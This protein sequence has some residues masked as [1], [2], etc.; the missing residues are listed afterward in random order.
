MKS[1]LTLTNPKVYA[2][3]KCE[4]ILFIQIA[5]LKK[6]STLK[7]SPFPLTQGIK[8]H[9]RALVLLSFLISVPSLWKLAALTIFDHA[10]W[11]HTRENPRHV[12]GLAR[13]YDVR[14]VQFV[15]K[16]KKLSH[17]MGLRGSQDLHCPSPIMAPGSMN[18]QISF[19]NANKTCILIDFISKLAK[20]LFNI[21]FLFFLFVIPLYVE[22][23]AIYHPIAL[24]SCLWKNDWHK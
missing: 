15:L 1:F 18:Y 8:L 12:P 21:I 11:Q 6:F 10:T 9:R 7:N 24:I 23:A 4:Q 22:N 5:K 3:N 14:V 20:P 19:S 2:Y 13:I 16:I 17:I